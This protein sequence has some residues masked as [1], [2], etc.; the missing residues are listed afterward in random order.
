MYLFLGYG[1]GI[2]ATIDVVGYGRYWQFLGE[3]C[4]HRDFNLARH[5]PDVVSQQRTDH[6]DPTMPWDGGQHDHQGARA[7]GWE[8]TTCPT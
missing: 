8:A 2:Y 6:Y 5:V 3:D 4:T 1:P 7:E